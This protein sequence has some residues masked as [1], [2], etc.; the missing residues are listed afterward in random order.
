[1]NY[2]Y[3]EKLEYNSI[4]KIY[5]L[6]ITTFSGDIQTARLGYFVADRKHNMRLDLISIDL[7]GTNKWVGTLCSLNNIYNMF[8]IKEGDVLIYLPVEDMANLNNV[9]DNI[10]YGNGAVAKTKDAFIN[11]LKTK[12]PDKTR[13]NFLTKRDNVNEQIPSISNNN[14]PEIQVVDGK[15]I[16]TSPIANTIVSDTTLP[17]D[18]T[19]ASIPTDTEESL[20]RILVNQYIKYLNT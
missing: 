1:M 6:T 9:P 2:D 17:K 10:K 4:D 16:L 18:E 14:A 7:Y 12:K 13:A 8:S 5:D 15:I 3:T 20:T 19:V 11:L